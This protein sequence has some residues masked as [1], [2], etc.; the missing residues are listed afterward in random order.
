MMKS[1]RAR[2]MDL[3]SMKMGVNRLSMRMVVS[4]RRRS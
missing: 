4:L 3:S 2:M 1:E